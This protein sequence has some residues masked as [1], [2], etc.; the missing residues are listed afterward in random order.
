MDLAVQYLIKTMEYDIERIEGLIIAI[1]YFYQTGQY[2][3]VNALY[4]RFK[5]YNKQPQQKLF[6]NMHFYRDRLE[7]FNGISAHFVND[8]QSG[9]HCCKHVLINGLM[10]LNELTVTLNNLLCYREMMEK[11]DTL[12]LFQAIDDLFYNF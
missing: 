8:K 1:E 5:S 6:I 11:E 2:I 10:G 9:Y 4:H 7:F 12:T 3:L